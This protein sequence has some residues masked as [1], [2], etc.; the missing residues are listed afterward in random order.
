MKRHKNFF[1]I[2]GVEGA[3][4]ST[5]S[6]LVKAKLES[7]DKEVFLTREPGGKGL[8][9][10]EDIREIIMKHGDIDS[11]T[12]L[13]LFNASRREHMVKKIIPNLKENKIVI[14]DRFTDSTLVYQGIVKGISEDIIISANKIATQNIQPSLTFI[15]DIDPKIGI[16]RIINNERNTNRFDNESLEFHNKIRE[17]YKKLL[18]QNKER[19]I[20]INSNQKKEVI[21][22]EIVNKILNYED[23]L[24]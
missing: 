9:F 8:A 4:K 15:L 11:I 17:G 24:N 5:I 10:A 3:G 21:V 16:E 22:D 20:L 1:T 23:K 2:E 12:E 19:Y 7:L 13:L 18:N 14:S 6:K